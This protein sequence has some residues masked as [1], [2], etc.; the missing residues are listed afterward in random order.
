MPY[1]RT[2]INNLREEIPHENPG[3]SRLMAICVALAA[4]LAVVRERLDTVERLAE[5]AG[6]FRQAQVEAYEPD[7][8]ASAARD[9]LRQRL[10]KH[11]FRVIR[12]DGERAAQHLT[13]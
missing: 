8:P 12:M 10:L 5:Q 11:V 6:V 4:E 9:G 13:P 1:R 2:R 3:E 7:P